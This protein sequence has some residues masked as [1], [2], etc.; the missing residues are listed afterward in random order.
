MYDLLEAE[1]TDVGASEVYTTLKILGKNGYVEF[2]ND[3]YAV[4]GIPYNAGGETS[5]HT[6]DEDKKK[7]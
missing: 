2:Q 5:W 4:K 6:Y 7:K 1:Y 3:G